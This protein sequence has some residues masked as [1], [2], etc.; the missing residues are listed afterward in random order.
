MEYM[1]ILRKTSSPGTKLF[2]LQIFSKEGILKTKIF[3]K[4]KTEF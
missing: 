1:D 2:L 4:I 3:Q